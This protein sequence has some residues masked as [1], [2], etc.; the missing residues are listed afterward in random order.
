MKTELLNQTL[1]GFEDLSG[2]SDEVLN[3]DI[4]TANHNAK[5]VFA[6]L[7]A[8]PEEAQQV[9]THMTYKMGASALA[10]L[11]DFITAVNAQEWATAGGH[12]KS[13][14]WASSNSAAA[15]ALDNT[16]KIIGA[17]NSAR[18]SFDENFSG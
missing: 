18:A 2:V 10:G 3:N 1:R 15:T 14:S 4:G 8:L 11:T 17:D 16:I 5:S 13:S 12:I 7:D 9:I 6:N